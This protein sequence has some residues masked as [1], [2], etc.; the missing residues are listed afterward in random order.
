MEDKPQQEVDYLVQNQQLLPHFLEEHNNRLNHKL[1]CLVVHNNNSLPQVVVYLELNNNNQPRVEDYS[2]QQ[3]HKA[4]HHCLEV[5]SLP[6]KQA[7]SV[8]HLLLLQL[9]SDKLHL[10]NFNHH[11]YLEEQLQHLKLLLFLGLHPLNPKHLFMV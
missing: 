4:N 5:H 10:N 7:C 9:F 1:L 6:V 3:V 2:D 11:L 8:N